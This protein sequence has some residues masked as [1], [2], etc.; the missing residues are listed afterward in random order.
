VNKT[1]KVHRSSINSIST[2]PL[3]ANYFLTASDDTTMKLFDVRK[4]QNVKKYY[5]STRLSS[6]FCSDSH[7]K[8][9]TSAFFSPITG[10]HV[11]TTTESKIRLFDTSSILSRNISWL[12]ELNLFKS[13]SRAYSAQ[14][15]WHPNREDIFFFQSPTEKLK[16]YEVQI[17]VRKS[18]S[19][20]ELRQKK[21][22]DSM[23]IC[24]VYAP[25]NHVN[26]TWCPLVAH[27]P[28][29]NLLAT[30]TSCGCI[31]VFEG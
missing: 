2:H 13:K 5:N 28:L 22:A 3:D 4:M 6:F 16:A 25:E 17:K 15:S 12:Q 11:L 7:D 20:W 24:H 21:L 30:A 26:T 9:V 8:G 14:A 27:H 1:F 23:S 10:S 31:H 18:K 29:L 19:R